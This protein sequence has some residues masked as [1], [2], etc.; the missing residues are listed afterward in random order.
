MLENN[1]L[2]SL[3]YN[4][5]A[6]DEWR[7]TNQLSANVGVHF[8]GFQVDGEL[9]TSLQPR[10]SL[11]YQLNNRMALKSSFA[12]MAQF[13]NLLTSEAIGLPSDLWV[14]STA[15]IRPQE[16]W[17]VAGGIAAALNDQFDLTIE[18][19][20]KSMNNVI[21]YIEGASFVPDIFRETVWEDNLVQGKGEV[22]GLEF[23]LKKSVGKTTGW[24]GYTLSRNWR[25]FDEINAGQRYPFRFDRR[26]DISL[27]VNHRPSERIN[28]SFVWIYGTGNAVTIPRARFSTQPNTSPEE[29]FS[30]NIYPSEQLATGS[31]NNY[32]M[33][34]SHRLDASVSF[35]KKKKRYE[36]KWIFSVYNIYSH[37]NPY[38]VTEGEEPQVDA[39]GNVEWV[40]VLKEI[41]LLPI[42]PS[43][44]YTFKF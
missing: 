4:L 1:A 44:A 7:I 16:S 23:L 15:N 43:V 9:Y 36:R 20:Y 35:Y 12:S 37:V 27:V 30:Q 10:I 14:P 33:S 42:I 29:S 40:S 2:R 28:Y 31:K 34:A 13:V 21:S 18:G 41:G 39:Q 11:R 22:Y 25:Q 24:L 32:R 19:F 17:Q 5:F 3:E 8:A 26:H 6:E 38:F